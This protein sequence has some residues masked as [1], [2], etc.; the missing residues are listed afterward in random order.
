M[1]RSGEQLP[2]PSTFHTQTNPDPDQQSSNKIGRVS[3]PGLGQVEDFAVSQGALAEPKEFWS[4]KE[5]DTCLKLDGSKVIHKRKQENKV[6][7]GKQN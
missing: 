5:E 3:S 6:N 1:P 7:T 2:S 4:L